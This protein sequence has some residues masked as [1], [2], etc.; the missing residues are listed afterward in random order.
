[1]PTMMP[2]NNNANFQNK[3]GGF[4]QSDS[5]SGRRV[6]ANLC[7]EARHFIT[8]GEGDH[9]EVNEKNAEVLCLCVDRELK[10]LQDLLKKQLCTCTFWM[11]GAQHFEEM[12]SR[13]QA[14]SCTINCGSM[15]D[16]QFDALMWMINKF[17]KTN[18][19]KETQTAEQYL[20]TRLITHK[21]RA[22]DRV[23]D[24]AGKGQ[25][26]GRVRGHDEHQDRAETHDWTGDRRVPHH[27]IDTD[28]DEV[29]AP[30]FPEVPVL[31]RNETYDPGFGER[32]DPPMPRAAGP[33]RVP[34]GKVAAP[35]AHDSR[36]V[37]KARADSPPKR[38][39]DDI[40]ATFTGLK[41][42]GAVPGEIKSL[43]PSG[44]LWIFALEWS[45]GEKTEVSHKEVG[46]LLIKGGLTQERTEA[47]LLP[48]SCAATPQPAKRRVSMPKVNLPEPAEAMQT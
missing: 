45:D 27:K 3:G 41:V 6:T 42:G 38:T 31:P 40:L 16:R 1:M 34:K 17:N 14:L 39:S 11:N 7:A 28:E 44:D 19:I 22:H 8:D 23:M 9:L 21:K 15:S 47:L 32:D 20:K 2:W 5:I 29:P 26:H 37:D 25:G 24:R 10:G 43:R 35:N 48:L 36:G 30:R 12:Q 4:A 46:K 13:V 18:N 33:S